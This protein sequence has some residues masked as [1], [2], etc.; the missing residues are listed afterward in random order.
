MSASEDRGGR[1]LDLLRIL[2]GVVWSVNLLFIFLPQSA[3][4]YWNPTFFSSEAYSFAF[5]SVIGTGLPNFVAAYPMFFAS[6]IAIGSVYLAVAFL[7]GITTRLASFVGLVASVLFLLTQWNG[8]FVWG[9][10]TDVGPQPLYIAIYLA[11]LV[12]GAGRYWALDAHLWKAGDAR[13]AQLARWV[14]VPSG[15]S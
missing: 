13:L 5:S 8:I 7:F 15:G 14:S 10:G 12:G 3:T 6:L 4:N 2:L 9:Y 1:A 11:L